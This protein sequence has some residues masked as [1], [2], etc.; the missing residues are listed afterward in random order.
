MIPFNKIIRKEVQDETFGL[1]D[2][3]VVSMRCQE[4]VGV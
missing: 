3:A 1:L 4:S 2:L